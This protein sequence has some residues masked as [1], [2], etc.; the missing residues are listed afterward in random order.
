MENL[1]LRTN[2]LINTYRLE[3]SEEVNAALIQLIRSC[4]D[5]QNRKTNVKAFMTDWFLPVDTKKAPYNKFFNFL[6]TSLM[7][8]IA[9]LWLPIDYSKFPKDSYSVHSLWGTIYNKGDY[10][11]SHNHFGATFSFCYY[12]KMNNPPT[13]LRFES[14]D[15]DV[16]P[17][18]ST[19]V[20]FP[21]WIDH[22]VP[23]LDSD[24]ERI[25]LA[26]NILVK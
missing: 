6:H 22:E 7:D 18:D 10:T 24:G 16:V 1:V 5:K 23:Q 21:G 4:G 25:V 14:I 19:L 11:V 8:S 2:R 26:G 15:Y 13:P 17:V 3:D 12:L 9:K 20:I